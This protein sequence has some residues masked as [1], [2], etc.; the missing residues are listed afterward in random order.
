MVSEKKPANI[1]THYAFRAK[2]ADKNILTKLQT[3]Q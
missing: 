2:N 1:L 3:L